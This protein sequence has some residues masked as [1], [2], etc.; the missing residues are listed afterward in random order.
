MMLQI[1]GVGH[2][3]GDY[4]VEVLHAWPSG[5]ITDLSVSG[6][7][8]YNII[9]SGQVVNTASDADLLAALGSHT[10]VN[11]SIGSDGQSGIAAG[12]GPKTRYLGP[13]YSQTP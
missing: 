5:S 8:S 3:A 1:Y 9:Q 12:G 2:T 13:T 4:T 11:Y 6:A 7:D 10:L